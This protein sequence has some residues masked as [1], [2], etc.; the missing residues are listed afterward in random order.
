MSSFVKSQKAF[1][2]LLKEGVETFLVDRDSVS[3]LPVQL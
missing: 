3:Q 1:K 2:V